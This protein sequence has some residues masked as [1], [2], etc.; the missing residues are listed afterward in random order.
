MTGVEIVSK[1][2]RT[3]PIHWIGGRNDRVNSI[4]LDQ[5]NLVDCEWHSGW[6]KQGKTEQTEYL[7]PWQAPP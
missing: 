5:G 7:P 1:V 6:V 3:T 4:P 2:K